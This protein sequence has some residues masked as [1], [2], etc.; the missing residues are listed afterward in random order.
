MTSPHPSPNLWKLELLRYFFSPLL[1]NPYEWQFL[2]FRLL[3]LLQHK[4]YTNYKCYEI[5]N[6]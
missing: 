1:Q 6:T 4:V 3:F 2:F 5:K